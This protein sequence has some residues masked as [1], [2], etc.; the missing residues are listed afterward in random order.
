MLKK[1]AVIYWTGSGNTKMMAEAVAEGAGREG[2]DV[3][4]LAVGEASKEDVLMADG[5]ALGCPSMGNEVL[6]EAEMEPFVESFRKDDLEGK[7][8]AL[9][10]SYG[11]GDGQWM[12]DWA[13]RIK[14]CGGQLVAEGLTVQNTPD[15]VA[16]D[17]CRA[18]GAKLAAEI[19]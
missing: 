18:L 10:G 13:D 19:H 17:A 9:F 7:P 3:T 14:D 4:V 6:E 15:D 1:I 8:L 16:L 12:R 11:W 2:A 5:V